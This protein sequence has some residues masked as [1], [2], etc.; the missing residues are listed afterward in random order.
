MHRYLKDNIEEKSL[1]KFI[2]RINLSIEKGKI[3]FKKSELNEETEI[4]LNYDGLKL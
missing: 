2:A 1:H 4:T 3:I